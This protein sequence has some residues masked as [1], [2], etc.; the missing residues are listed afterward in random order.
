[1]LLEV[2]NLIKRYGDFLALDHITFAVKE[3]EIFGLL[4]PNGAG[5]TT[6][7]SIISSLTQY[8]G[9][10]VKFLGKEIKRHEMEVKQELGIVPQEIALFEDLTAYEN[11]DYFGRLY[12]LR[13]SLL[14]ERIAEALSFTGL[15]DRQK[16]RP[17]G[18][19]GGMKRRLNIAC[20]ILHHPKLIIMDEPTVGIDPQSRN[21]ILQSI[22]ELNKMGST[23]IY[24]SHYMEE[25]EEICTRVAIVDHGRVIAQGTKEELTAFVSTEEKLV[26]E[27]SS[28][29]YTVVEQIK[30]ISSIRE[31]S[32]KGTSLEVIGKKGEH[33]VSRVINLLSEAGIEILSLNVEKPSLE[34]VFLTLTGRSLRD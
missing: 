21:H 4:G 31:C 27:L 34:A 18:F 33:N 30:S 26:I 22:K 32:I 9:G 10:E 3:G 24:T 15:T 1:M 13:G 5:K 7:I 23:I 25:V 16:D 8:D 2:N 19:S 12:G 29:T 20:A 28:V 17:K 14:K 6:T 11:L